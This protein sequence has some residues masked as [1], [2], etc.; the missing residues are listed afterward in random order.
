MSEKEVKPNKNYGVAF[1]AAIKPIMLPLIVIALLLIVNVIYDPSYVKIYLNEKT[2]LLAGPIMLILDQAT[3]LVF[4]SIGMTIVTAATG[5]QDISVGSTLV[6]AAAFMA[7]FY[8]YNY[9]LPIIL[10]LISGCLIVMAACLFTGILVSYL[11]VQPMIASLILF[12][13]G[14]SIASIITDNS[15]PTV[16]GESFLVWGNNFEGFPIKTTL[17]ITVIGFVV[18]GLIMKFTTLGLYTK[19]VGI[20]EKSARLN[21]I[22][23]N[24]IKL[25]SFVILGVCVG[26]AGFVQAA[27]GTEITYMTVR[28]GIEMDAILAVAIGGNAL[29]GGKFSIAGSVMG[30]YAIYLINQ[31]LINFGVD[32]NQ[33][34]AYR[35]VVI[36][37]LVII[38]SDTVR[39]YL[40]G[41]VKKIKSMIKTKEVGS[42]V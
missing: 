24:F 13:A 15:C 12:T 30:A 29:S 37:I 32:G 34:K 27:R 2:G 40:G 11:K 26:V 28:D 1:I 8:S 22:N 7:Q 38:S 16:K 36:F 41:L 17:I 6:I 33:Q 9:K 25:L 21:G 18:V 3:E 35:A 20:N 4:L 19:A 39:E 10:V 42:D 31:L 23:P 5:G 14:R